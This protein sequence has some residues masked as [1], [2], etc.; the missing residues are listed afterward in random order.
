MRN[1]LILLSVLFLAHFSMGQ[2][3]TGYVPRKQ[4]PHFQKS[5]VDHSKFSKLHKDFESPQEVTNTCLSCHTERGKEIMETAHWN[6]ERAAYTEEEGV[7]YFGKQN[8]INNFCIGISGSEGACTRCHIGYGYKDKNFD[9]SNQSNIDCLVC[10]D[11]SGTYQKQPGKAGYPYPQIDLS[12]AAQNVGYPKKDNCGVCHFYS[13]GGNNVKNGTLDKAL[14]NTT[15]DVDVHM[16]KNGSDM[17]CVECHETTKH[18]MKGKYYGVSSMDRNRAECSQC[19]TET[20]HED[21]LLNE[22]TKKVSCQACHIPQYAKVNPTKLNWDW[23]TATKLNEEGEPFAINNDEGQHSYL[24]IKGS[25]EWGSNLE[26]NYIWFNGT[27]DHHFLTDRIE[28]VPV[29]MNTLHG[30]YRDKESKI[31]PVKIHRGKQPYDKKFNRMVQMKLWDKEKGQGALWKDFNWENSL[32]AGMDYIGL[33]YSGNY[34]F[35]KTEMTLPL[36]H[37]VSPADK[38]VSCTECHTRDDSR[39]ESLTDFYMPRR[40]QNAAIDSGGILLII[41]S[42]LGVL[43][44]ATIRIFSYRKRRNNTKT[45]NNA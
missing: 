5:S 38:A 35:V 22:H 4:D 3:E 21:N 8:L 19:H 28:E 33:P 26:P 7:T 30:S 45:N 37:M 42:I 23:S 17:S 29:Q 6:W 14:L 40:D 2:T 15:K 11:N 44:H 12:H 18:Q 20:P 24:S 27:A 10:H 1:I 32:E 25:F 31:W 13:A 43:T 36:S 16:A 9:F 34:G 41:F 39:I